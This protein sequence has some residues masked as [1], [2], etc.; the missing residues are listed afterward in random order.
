[1]IKFSSVK[2]GS[3]GTSVIVLQCLFRAMQYLGAD[4]KPLKIDGRCGTNTVYAINHFQTTQRAYGFECGTDGKNDGS[5]G[6]SCWERL[7]GI[8]VDA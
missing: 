4:G 2:E 6:P 7:L 3:V 8:K 1:M 5:F